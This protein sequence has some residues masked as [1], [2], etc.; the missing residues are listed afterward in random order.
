MLRTEFFAGSASAQASRWKTS[1]LLER[2]G[3][4]S[5]NLVNCYLS[6][7]YCVACSFLMILC[8]PSL[9]NK[10]F[11]TKR[12]SDRGILGKKTRSYFHPVKFLFLSKKIKLRLGSNQSERKVFFAS[13]ILL[14][15]KCDEYIRSVSRTTE[16][17]YRS[18]YRRDIEMS[19]GR[20]TSLQPG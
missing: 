14:R 7:H 6:F 18:L 5:L 9:W 19:N 10:I 1:A 12:H 2:R 4:K 16:S 3:L 15:K 8:W 17:R 20:S 13:C 11:K